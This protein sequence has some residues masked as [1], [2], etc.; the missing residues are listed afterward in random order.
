MHIDWTA[1]GTWATFLTCLV[2]G[3]VVY[4]RMTQKV[5]DNTDD[6]REVRND[7]KDVNTKLETQG[8]EIVRIKAHIG[9]D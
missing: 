5:V 8:N 4:G 9:I 2:T 1:L 7:I 6:I 3:L